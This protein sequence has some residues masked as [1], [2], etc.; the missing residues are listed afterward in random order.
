MNSSAGFLNLLQSIDAFFPVGAFTLSNGLEDYVACGRMTDSADLRQ[1]LGGFMQLF[2]YNDLGIA[3]WAYRH[4]QSA[5]DILE[6][7]H[8]AAACKG[9]REVRTGT[10]R[11][12]AR[13][14]KART[15]MGDC[16]GQLERY[17]AA[18][19]AGQAYGI[20]PIALG[21]YG[22]EVGMALHMLLVMYGYSVL[23][24]IVNNA[25]K[26]VPLGQMDGQRILFECMRELEALADRAA[27]VDISEIGMSGA[28]YEIH[29]MNHERLYSRQY[30]S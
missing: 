4:F 13:Y 19:A 29:C 25:V 12:C 11:M 27:Q 3:A 2:P 16:Q 6:L 15:A 1:Y 17:S 23:S 9:A 20:H 7:D 28:A 10:M 18:I 22:A 5:S 26:L 14:L 30:S 24:A 8:A 21:I